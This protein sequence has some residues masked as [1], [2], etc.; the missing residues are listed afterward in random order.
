MEHSKSS[1][2]NDCL[3]YSF[4]RVADVKAAAK[5]AFVCGHPF[6][7][8]LSV[9]I[10]GLGCIFNIVEFY[11]SHAGFAADVAFGSHDTHPRIAE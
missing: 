1:F 9:G 2:G 6:A 3:F 7:E 5:L 11:L 8:C 10:S 4:V